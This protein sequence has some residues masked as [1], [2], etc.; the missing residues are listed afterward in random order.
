MPTPNF[1]LIGPG[2][3]GTTWAYNA[4]NAHPLVCMATTKETMFFNEYYHK[5]YNWYLSFFSHCNEQSLIGEVT[6]TYIFSELAPQRMYDFNNALQ[7]IT[8][9]RNPIDRAFSHY[10]FLLRNGEHSG[11]FEEIIE[12]RPDLL[13]RGL[14]FIYLNHYLNFFPF[15]QVNILFFDDL[16][17][18]PFSF[19]N[20]L[21]SILDISADY[22]AL[23]TANENKLPASAA[24][25]RLIAKLVKK[26]ALKTRDLGRPDWV[27]KIKNSRL[28]KLF[29]RQYTQYP[30]M[31]SDIRKRLEDYFYDDVEQLSELTNQDLIKQWFQY[32][33]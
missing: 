1:I 31:N 3:S 28:T 2:K 25:S 13:E 7:L 6:N 19:G 12:K 11:S 4:L 8:I 21:F 14:Y 9:L 22:S 20:Y 16:Q 15:K 18:D 33:D 23:Q 24:R 10:L 29:Y 5:G 17:N 30:T 26:L 27:T 32:V